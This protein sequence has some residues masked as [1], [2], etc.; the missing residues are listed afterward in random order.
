MKRVV[1]SAVLSL[2]LGCFCIVPFSFTSTVRDAQG[3]DTLFLPISFLIIAIPVML[4]SFGIFLTISSVLSKNKIKVN[5]KTIFSIAITIFLII[6]IPIIIVFSF[7]LALYVAADNIR[8]E[9]QEQTDEVFGNLDIGFDDI[10]IDIN[11]RIGYYYL[12]NNRD[13]NIENIEFDILLTFN[14][15]ERIQR[16]NNLEIYVEVID[17]DSNAA[18]DLGWFPL[19]SISSGTNEITLNA[20]RRA[21]FIYCEDNRFVQFDRVEIVLKDIDLRFEETYT[22]NLDS[23][24]SQE[25]FDIKNSVKDIYNSNQ[26]DGNYEPRCL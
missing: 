10:Q 21:D 8:E 3:W 9:S 15:N 12:S 24:F 6:I 13:Q 19:N 20:D 22:L 23:S 16:S 2:L 18:V 5:K 26:L 7:Y 11:E 25:Y 14:S 4:I 17:D 1:I